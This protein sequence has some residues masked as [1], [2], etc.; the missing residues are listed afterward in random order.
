M[1]RFAGKM[2]D[3]WMT[4]TAV[5]VVPGARSKVGFVLA[6]SP[7]MYLLLTMLLGV[8]RYDSSTLGAAALRLS[9]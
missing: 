7:P 1:R 2:P 6:V 5:V 3:R 9:S 8:V 4:H